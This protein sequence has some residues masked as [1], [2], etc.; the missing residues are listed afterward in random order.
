MPVSREEKRKLNSQ[1]FKIIDI[2][3]KPESVITEE[4]PEVKPAKKA[5]KGA[6]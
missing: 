2:K 3:F 5:K 4:K 6:S 1:G